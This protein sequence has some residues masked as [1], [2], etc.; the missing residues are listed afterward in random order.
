MAL[1][2]SK[3]HKVCALSKLYYSSVNHLSGYVWPLGDIYDLCETYMTFGRH[4]WPSGDICIDIAFGKY[5]VLWFVGFNINA[6]SSHYIGL[7][8]KLGNL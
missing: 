4:V 3:L 1:H 2:Y 8:K 7:E 5:N 6:Q